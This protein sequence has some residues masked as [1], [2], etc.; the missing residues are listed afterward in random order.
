MAGPTYHLTDAGVPSTY[1][2]GSGY[3]PDV[4]F[5]KELQALAEIGMIDRQDARIRLT[6]RGLMVANDVAERFIT[7]A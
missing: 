5:G 2:Q 7:L 4:V 1:D 6:H 3:D